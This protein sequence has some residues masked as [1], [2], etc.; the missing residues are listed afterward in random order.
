VI[1]VVALVVLVASVPCTGGRLGRLAHLDLRRPWL[2]AAGFAAQLAVVSAFPDMEPGLATALHLASYAVAGA[3]LVLNRH[4]RWMWLVG[5][6]AALNAVAIAAN[7]GVM[8]ASARAYRIAGL[9]TTG[10]DFANSRPLEHPRLL[11]LGDVFAVPAGWP[12]ANVFS[13]G[14]VVLT[15]GAGVLLHAAGRA[16]HRPT[17]TAAGE[18]AS[19]LHPCR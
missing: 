2:V 6:G 8:P 10:P 9:A 19:T 1:V 7:G 5:V 18:P 11:P 13:V 16:Q 15:V 17:R 4:I 3:F 14:D 12:L